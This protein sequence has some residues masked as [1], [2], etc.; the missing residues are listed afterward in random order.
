MHK[1]AFHQS[2][3]VGVQRFKDVCVRMSDCLAVNLCMCGCDI[4]LQGWLSVI[5]WH[6]RR[7][8]SCRRSCDVAGKV[9][10]IVAFRLLEGAYVCWLL[11]PI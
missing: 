1:K 2:Y 6:Q 7:V 5:V 3:P 9:C 8:T 4:Y 10:V 11:C